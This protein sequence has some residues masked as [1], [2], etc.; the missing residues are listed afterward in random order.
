MKLDDNLKKSGTLRNKLNYNR[1]DTKKDV[2]ESK[3]NTRNIQKFQNRLKKQSSTS[4]PKD[5]QTRV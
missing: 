1:K 5:I 4:P 3:I 2:A